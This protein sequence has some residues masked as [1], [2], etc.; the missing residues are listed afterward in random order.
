MGAR[1]SPAA[2]KPGVYLATHSNSEKKA[3]NPEHVNHSRRF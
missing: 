1:R 2:L 3:K